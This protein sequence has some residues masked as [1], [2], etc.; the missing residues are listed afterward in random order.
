MRMVWDKALALE[1]IHPGLVRLPGFICHEKELPPYYQRDD[2]LHQLL[3]VS[4]AFSQW[5]MPRPWLAARRL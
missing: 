5:S 3:A 2:Q 4:R 1:S